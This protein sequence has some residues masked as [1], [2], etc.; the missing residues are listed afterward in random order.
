MIDY[1]HFQT[2]SDLQEQIEREKRSSRTIGRVLMAG[3]AAVALTG[4]LMFQ[5]AKAVDKTA[6]NQER[7]YSQQAVQLS[8]EQEEYRSFFVRHGSP[9]PEAMALAV[10]QTRRPALMAAIAVVESN[11]NP[12]AVGD[13]GES[14]G[15]FQ[16]QPKHHGPVSASPV[17]QALQAERILDE[18]VQASRG[19]L[20]HALA[21]YNGGSNP[22]VISDRYALKVMRLA[23]VR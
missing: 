10:S 7:Y 18:L 8:A 9:Q 2:V 3:A 22:P 11:G 19:R 4:L 15:A 20:R 1:K 23:G 6:E 16:V 5:C 21:R 13:G 12:A 14:L 17:Q